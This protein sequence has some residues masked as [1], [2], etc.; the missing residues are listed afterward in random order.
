MRH[1]VHFRRIASQLRQTFSRICVFYIGAGTQVSEGNNP[2]VVQPE[3][4]VLYTSVTRRIDDI[5][6]TAQTH[7]S[8]FVGNTHDRR[9]RRCIGVVASEANIVQAVDSASGIGCP[10][11]DTRIDFGN[12]ESGIAKLRHRHLH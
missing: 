6:V 7:F 11:H 10:D 9:R 8:E 4:I 2:G 12:V 5:R 3:T 1:G